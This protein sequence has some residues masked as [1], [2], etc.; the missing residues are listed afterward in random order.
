[1]SSSLEKGMT[2]VY[3]MALPMAALAGAV[4]APSA[5]ALDRWLGGRFRRATNMASA[6]AIGGQPLAIAP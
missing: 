3:I 5:Y 2:F 1:M 4:L 6:F